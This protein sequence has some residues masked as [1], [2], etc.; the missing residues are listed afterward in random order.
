MIGVFLLQDIGGVKFG[1][2]GG[3]FGFLPFGVC[4]GEEIFEFGR[5]FLLSG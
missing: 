4:S 3:A 1:A 2:G 5:N